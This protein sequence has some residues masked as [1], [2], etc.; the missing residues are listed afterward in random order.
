MQ[1]GVEAEAER[2]FDSAVQ[3]CRSMGMVRA[4]HSSSTAGTSQFILNRIGS[5]LGPP[6]KIDAERRGL[7]AISTD[8]SRLSSSSKKIRISSRARC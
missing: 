7:P 8:A 3:L 2:L 4:G 5:V 6:M 1:S